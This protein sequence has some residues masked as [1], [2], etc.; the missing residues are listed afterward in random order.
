MSRL[1]DTWCFVSTQAISICLST[2]E[3]ACDTKINASFKRA[4]LEKKIIQQQTK[5]VFVQNLSYE[6]EF[7]LQVHF[8]ANQT[9][10]HNKGFARRF[11]LKHRTR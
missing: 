4:D 9:Y 10:L 7:R 6:N 3:Y 11:V 5:R 2:Q 1:S 8:H